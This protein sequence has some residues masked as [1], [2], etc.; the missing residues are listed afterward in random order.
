MG[1]SFKKYEFIG[2]VENIYSHD[3]EK[4]HEIN[5]VFNAKIGRIKTD[6][7]EKH[8]DFS[9]VNIKELSQVEILPITLKKAVLKWLKDKKRFWASEATI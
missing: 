1:I 6:S 5:L 9:L 4:H 2:A 3:K 8:I 7:K